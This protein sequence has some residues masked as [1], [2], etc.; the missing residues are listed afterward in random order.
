MIDAAL[1]SRLA[2]RRTVPWTVDRPTV[3]WHIAAM[4]HWCEVV[5]EQLALLATADLRDVTACVLGTDA[6]AARCIDAAEDRGINLHVAFHHPNFDLYELPTLALVHRWAKATPLGA[7][8]YFHTKGVSAPDDPNKQH[9]RRLMG[10]H[11]IAN[12]RENLK[13]LADHD[14][15]GVNYQDYPIMPHFAGNFWMARA[16][17]IADLPDLASYQ[18]N[19]PAEKILCGAPWARACAEAWLLA[20]PWHRI[21]SLCCRGE[22]FWTGDRVFDFEII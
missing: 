5:T 13:L 16:D 18:A 9:W 15:V 4:G 3:F 14:A 1:R 22:T 20:W 12:W 10:R 17:W 6:Q 21:V 19:A 8:I 7:A 2:S 11:V